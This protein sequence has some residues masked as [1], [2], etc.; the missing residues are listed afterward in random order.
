MRACLDSVFGF[1]HQCA[2]LWSP[3]VC[4][5]NTFVVV[6]FSMKAQKPLFGI[7]ENVRGI[8]RCLPQVLSHLRSSNLHFVTH[9]DVDSKELGKELARPRVYFLLIRKDVAIDES[10][11][12]KHE[13]AKMVIKLLRCKPQICIQKLLFPR[14]HPL[15]VRQRSRCKAGRCRCRAC[16]RSQCKE[17]FSTAPSAGACKWRHRHWA[18]IKKHSLQ[19]SQISERMKSIPVLPGLRTPKSRHALAC[20][21][22]KD[23]QAQFINVG[24]SLGRG[25]TGVTIVPTLTPRGGMFI[26]EQNRILTAQETMC[27][28]GF[29]MHKLDLKGITNSEMMKIGGNAMEATSLAAAFMACMRLLDPKRF[30]DARS[31]KVQKVSKFMRFS[32]LLA[33]IHK[34]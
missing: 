12:M 26:T 25:S 28:M 7:L 29:P 14:S 33:S 30:D 4:C 10:D 24:Q 13:L 18:F 5:A 20:S 3:R 17:S 31:K 27:L 19:A 34:M 16:K 2:L 15:V 23:P 11:E 1:S 21:L 9:I 32:G 8:K 22:E 6:V